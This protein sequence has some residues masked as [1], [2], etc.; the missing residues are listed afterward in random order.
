MPTTVA[1]VK[2]L[3]ACVILYVCLFVRMIKIKTVESKITKLG[4]GIVQST[5]RY[6]THQLVLCQKAKNQGH[7]VTISHNLTLTCKST[8]YDNCNFVTR[9]LFKESY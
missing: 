1:G 4:T 2:R 8:F 5:S 7:R 6:R 9:M 3:D